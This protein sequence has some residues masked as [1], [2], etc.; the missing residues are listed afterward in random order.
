MAKILVTGSNGQ[1]GNELRELSLQSPH[2]FLFTDVQELDITNPQ[3]IAE[4]MAQFRPQYLL[5][6]AAYTAVDKAETEHDAARLINATAVGHLATACRNVQ[7]RLVHVST[8]Y[9]YDGHAHK[10]IA[11]TATTH[12]RS[13]Y[14]QTKL[15]G[16]ELARLAEEYL[17]VRTAW[18]YSAFGNNFVKTMLRLGRERGQLSVV[19]DQIGSPTYARDLAAALIQIIDTVE[20]GQKPFLSGVYHYANEGVAS[21]YDF[22]Q[23][24]FQIAQVSCQVSPIPSSA[25]PTP[26]QRPFY[27]LMA[28]EKIKEH[29]ALHIPYWRHSLEACLARLA[30][31]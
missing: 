18:L 31:G 24:I 22:A 25:Y 15:E 11:E 16:E 13:I 14:G 4:L 7:C 23:A 26:A 27:S 20:Q 17:I 10:P 1:L 8:D 3:A 29:Y 6:C 21:W 2:Q 9:V 30:Q 28:K 12:P 5:N 19:Y